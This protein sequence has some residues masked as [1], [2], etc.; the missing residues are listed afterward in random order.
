[1]YK[2]LL[3]SVFLEYKKQRRHTHKDF[4]V[5]HGTLA[6]GDPAPPVNN[7]TSELF[8]FALTLT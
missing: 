4:N 6:E 5:G 8:F 1:M 2:M 7:L 3:R